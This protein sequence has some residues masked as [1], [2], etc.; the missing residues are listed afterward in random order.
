MTSAQCQS[1][2]DLD[3]ELVL[4]VDISIPASFNAA[5]LTPSA[6]LPHW[7]RI[8]T[9]ADGIGGSSVV[10]STYKRQLLVLHVRFLKPQDVQ[11]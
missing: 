10:P 5:T 11:P 3:T 6:I 4:A 8:A 2:F 9:G 7:L 1:F